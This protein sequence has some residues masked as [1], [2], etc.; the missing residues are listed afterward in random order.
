[1]GPTKITSKYRHASIY[2]QILAA[3]LICAGHVLAAEPMANAC[4]VDGCEVKILEVKPAGDELALS[5]QGQL[6]ARCF[7]K[8]SPCLVGRTTLTSSKLA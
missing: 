2:L 7:E 4:P 5:V 8:P 6:H 3:N 1:M